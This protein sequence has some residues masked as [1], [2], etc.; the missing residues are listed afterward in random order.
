MDKVS[1][2]RKLKKKYRLHDRQVCYMGD[3]EFDLPL[4]RIA[5]FS[6]APSDALEAVTSEVDYVAVNEGGRG[7]VREVIDMILLAQGAR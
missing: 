6:A 1:V 5:G 2:Y 3:D 7:A 4:L